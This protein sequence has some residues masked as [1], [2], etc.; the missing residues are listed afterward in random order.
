MRKRVIQSSSLQL[1]DWVYFGKKVSERLNEP[2]PDM[3]LDKLSLNENL[4]AILSYVE[5]RNA[6]F[7]VASVSEYH[8][9]L[10]TKD[11][12]FLRVLYDMIDPISIT[13]DI[14]STNG[15]YKL[16]DLGEGCNGYGTK[17]GDYTITYISHY[18]LPVLTIEQDNLMEHRTCVTLVDEVYDVHGLQNAYRMCGL[19][20]L[21]DMFVV[22]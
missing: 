13:E 18:G 11:E 14:L 6:P 19:G 9:D 7:K 17:Y 15:W 20:E 12:T 22:E 2:E 21:A 16:K 8:I 1:G 10:I 3:L 4:G 5:Y